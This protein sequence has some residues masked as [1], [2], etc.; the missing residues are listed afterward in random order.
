[1]GRILYGHG[2]EF[3]RLVDVTI[4]KSAIE[5]S[6]S[7][8]T[9]NSKWEDMENEEYYVIRNGT[10]HVECNSSEGL[11]RYWFRNVEKENILNVWLRS[12]KFTI[13]DLDSKS[14]RSSTKLGTNVRSTADENVGRVE[15]FT[16]ALTRIEYVNLYHTMSDWY[17]CFL[18]MRFHNQTSQDVNI[19]LID[20]HPP[21]LLDPVWGVL[22]HSATRIKHLKNI[23]TIFRNL[24][25]GIHGSNNRLDQHFLPSLPL[26]EEFREFFLE[27]FQMLSK[28]RSIDCLHPSVLII[29]RQ[30]YVTHRRNPS[31]FVS[32]KIHN[33]EELM[34]SLKHDFVNF[35][36]RAIQLERLSMRDQLE[37]VVDTDI[38]I[39]MHGAGLTHAI[40]LSPGAALIELFPA[41]H[42]QSNIHFRAIAR[43]RHLAYQRW[44]NDDWRM[45]LANRSTIVSIRGISERLRRAAADICPSLKMFPPSEPSN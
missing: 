8:W 40:F 41:Y 6:R 1:M 21:G 44:T 5:S 3:A 39:G 12:L 31:G 18:L 4:D 11:H 16:I 35:R 23:K 32:R 37:A 34:T 45:E 28:Q 30:D 2:R 26:V 14:G 27:R 25:W 42:G 7:E 15:D 36:F 9:N 43:W 17:N 29:R 10:F 24:V 19:L 33:M 22:F 20:N 38:L 13:N